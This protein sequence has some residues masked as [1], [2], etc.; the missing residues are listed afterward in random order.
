MRLFD[1]LLRPSPE[2]RRGWMLLGLGGIALLLM[3]GCVTRST[4]EEDTGRLE[5]DN[6]QLEIRVKNLTR[7]NSSLDAERV[8]LAD[9]LEDLH[10]ARTTLERDVA[11]LQET[12]R[13]LGE[14]L[15]ERDAQVDELSKV[16]STYEALVDDL[17]SDLTAGRIQIEQLRDGIRLNLPQDILFASGSATLHDTGQVVIRRVADRL[18]KVGHR[19]EV[20][21]H[22]DNVPVSGRLAA[23]FGSNWELA[24]ARAAQVVRL[25]EGEGVEPHRLTAISFGE[26]APVDDNGS[27]EGRAHNRRI[28]IRLI[29]VKGTEGG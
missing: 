10:Q 6:K 24:G 22:S 9:E 1:T 18:K 7:A 28:E 26:N 17:E 23:R 4:Y 12:K 19:V 16:S 14:H 15:R 29:P 21:G 20:Q 13:L 11:K 2:G 25:F 8:K 5:A 27:P 3:L